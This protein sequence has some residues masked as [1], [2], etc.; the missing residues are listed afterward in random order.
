MY[1]L[2]PATPDDAEAI[3]EVY[4][5]SRRAFLP[6]APLMHTDDEVRQWLRELVIPVFDVTV[7]TR[8]DAVVGMMVLSRD[9]ESGWIDQLYLHPEH[10]GQGLGTLLLDRAKSTLG[11]PIRLYSFARNHD[12]QRF[13]ERNGFTAL[14]HGDGSGN[15]EHCPDTLFEWLA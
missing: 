1:Q 4:L 9:G 13:Y 10:V 14:S 5:A 8:G 12:A 6:Y 15:E 3:A 2:R 7:A 11:S